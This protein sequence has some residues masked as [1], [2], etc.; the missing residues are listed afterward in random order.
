VLVGGRVVKR[1][2]KIDGAER[3]CALLER[4]S[5]RLQAEVERR[6]G[7]RAVIE[8]GLVALQAAARPGPTR[9]AAS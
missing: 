9:S 4:S 1:D 8:S 3:A 2:G 7:T 6:G 5:A